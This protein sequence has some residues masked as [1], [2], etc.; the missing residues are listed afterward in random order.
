[1]A[2]AVVS[3]SNSTA[4]D[5]ENVQPVAETMHIV[6]QNSPSSQLATMDTQEASLDSTS[7]PGT[8]SATGFWGFLCPLCPTIE[9]QCFAH[10]KDSYLIGR[11]NDCDIHLNRRLLDDTTLHIISK[12]HCRIYRETVDEDSIV[13]IED[14]IFYFAPGTAI[15]CSYNK[16]FPAEVTGRYTVYKRLGSGASGTVHLVIRHDDLQRFAVK[17]IPK[18]HLTSLSSQPLGGIGSCILQEVEALHAVDHPCIIR[19]EEVIPTATN[20]YIFMELGSGGELFDKIGKDGKIKEQTAKL[21]FYQLAMAVT[22]LHRKGITHRDLKPEN[23]LL[24]NNEE[25]T[26]VKVSDFGLSKF[27][28][29]SSMKTFCGTIHYIAPEIIEHSRYTPQVDVWSYGVMLFVALSGYPPFS[30]AYNDMKLKESIVK[31]R[32]FFHPKAWE[33]V[34]ELAKDLVRK[35]VVCEPSKRLTPMQILDHPWFDDLDMRR[36]VASLLDVSVESLPL[37]DEVDL[38]NW[39]ESDTQ[40]F[41]A[42]SID[43]EDEDETISVPAPGSFWAAPAPPDTSKEITLQYSTTDRSSDEECS[44]PGPVPLTRQESISREVITDDDEK[45]QVVDSSMAS[46]QGLP[47]GEQVPPTKRRRVCDLNRTV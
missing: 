18:K 34:S 43:T 5:K 41:N 26:L 30:E 33:G 11:G 47:I 2:A 42:L 44:T 13:M 27:L 45:C 37:I 40:E 17:V 15:L 29:Q 22:H 38:D 32:L 19:V 6:D 46:A 4:S 20:V 16:D 39:E 24:A 35:T 28:D 10:G 1:M 25:E 23:I 36:K 31:G 21:Y 7:A 9:R 8:A 3:N 12:H 14:L